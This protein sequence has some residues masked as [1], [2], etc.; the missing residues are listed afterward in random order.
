M[1]DITP[2]K[3][4]VEQY[5]SGRLADE[6]LHLCPVTGDAGFREYFRTNTQPSSIVAFA[7]PEHE[8]NLAFVTKGLALAA[9]GV[10]VPKVYAV[11]YTRGFLLQE[12]L[13]DRLFLE[14]LCAGTVD[15][16]YGR[17]E[18]TLLK[19]QGLA[20]DE[21]VFPCYDEALLQREMALF[22][23]WFVARL[24]GV[25]GDESKPEITAAV[26]TALVD[27]ALQQPQVVVHRD[28]HSRNLLD[29]SDGGVGVIDF[30]DAVVGPLC[31][32]LAS[33]LRDCYIRWSPA[34]V[35]ARVEA[36]RCLLLKEVAAGNLAINVP[37]SATFM[38]W[39]D[40]MGL[41]RHLKV[42]GIFARLSLRDGK[43][44]YLKDLPLVIRYTLDV[45]KKYPETQAFYHW[46]V[47]CLEPRLQE[48]SWYQSWQS[49]GDVQA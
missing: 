29:L 34:L 6:G 46:F 42:L 12:D 14:G 10:H 18:Q 1:H 23:E 9:G 22:P 24:L 21:V 33:L 5:Q 48:Q 31:Y 44:R 8:D 37:D 2:L 7:P 17:A 45:A 38:R 27:N 49:A 15:A 41:Q 47:E 32:D 19:I 20:A 4:W 11:D 3:V 13:G 26:F 30:Q 35:E 16:M 43:T 28:Y 40:L 25:A 36:F 39:F